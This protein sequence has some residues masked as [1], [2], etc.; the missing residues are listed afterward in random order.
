MKYSPASPNCFSIRASAPIASSFFWIT[1]P[2][3]SVNVSTASSGDPN[4]LAST[5]KTYVRSFSTLNLN[6]SASF[7]PP[8]RPLMTTGRV[9]ES[10]GFDFEDVCSVLLYLELE[11]VRFLSPADAPVDDDRQ[12]HRIGWLRL[13]RRMFGPSRP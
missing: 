8:M 12:G 4:R 11:L 13:R 7:S 5:S 10:A 6:W 3:A 2:L 1:V 9:T